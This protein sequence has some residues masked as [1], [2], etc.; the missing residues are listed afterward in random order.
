[1]SLQVEKLEKNMAKLTI[2]VPAEELEAAIQNLS[3]ENQE[4]SDSSDSSN[5]NGQDSNTAKPD[6]PATGDASSNFAW[7]LLACSGIL[8]LIVN[9]VNQKRKGSYKN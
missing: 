5:N 3:T 2:E 4:D 9:F 8:L 6:S 1:M 7:I